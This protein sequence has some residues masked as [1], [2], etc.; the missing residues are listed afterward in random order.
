L[1]PCAPTE[2]GGQRRSEM[3]LNNVPAPLRAIRVRFSDS[4]VCTA[5]TVKNVFPR[6]CFSLDPPGA[7]GRH[8]VVKCRFQ[9]E[10]LPVGFVELLAEVLYLARLDEVDGAATEAAARH[11]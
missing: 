10:A 3:Y 1:R 6:G 5:A 2:N 8:T 4:P 9:R 11:P 7:G